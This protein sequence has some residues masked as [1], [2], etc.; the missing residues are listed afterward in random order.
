MKRK[1]LLH[2]LFIALPILIFM[3]VYMVWFGAVER[4]DFSQCTEIHCALDDKIPFCE[5][6]IVPYLLWFLFVAA[7]AV[8]QL[9]ADEKEFRELCAVLMSG[10]FVFLVL[11]SM[12]PNIL[13]LRPEELPRDNVFCRMVERLY[14]TDTPTNVMPSIHVYNT[15]AILFSVF[16]SQGRITGN[17]AV[18]AGCTVLSVSIILAT[19]LLK[20][21]SVMD[22]TGAFIMFAVFQTLFIKVF[23]SEEESEKALMTA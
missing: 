4:T 10:M 11:S 8:Y 5:Y 6:F 14:A 13:F 2:K 3:A 9:F 1:L 17:T 23:S 16:R 7:G 21:H 12:F 22:V 15:L 19:M 18:K 20:Q